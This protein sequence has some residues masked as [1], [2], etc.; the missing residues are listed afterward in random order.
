MKMSIINL[1]G[2]VCAT[3]FAPALGATLVPDA[4]REVAP[5]CVG[6]CDNSGAV[7]VDEVVRGL[8]IAL[9]SLP[10]DQCPPLDC[11]A[12][13]Q[14]TVDC[15]IEA[16]DG[17]LTGCASAPTATPTP[18]GTTIPLSTTTPT[19]TSPAAPTATSTPT[20]TMTPS[21]CGTFLTLWGGFG[22]GPGQF[23]FPAGVAVDGNGNVFVVDV[24]NSR[25]Q[26]FTNG[27]PFVGYH[28][29]VRVR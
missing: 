9:G 2:F 28:K 26:E 15:L 29:L 8:S 6:D 11:N 1:L 16:V 27:G 23:K 20:P 21:S 10:L 14:V 12:T 5:P 7:T 13:G 24:E 17:E 18:T 19:S 25:I 3:V 22:T 4:G